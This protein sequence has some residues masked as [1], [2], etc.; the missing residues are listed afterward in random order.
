MTMTKDW[1]ELWFDS[2]YYDILYQHRD[3][4]EAQQFINGLLKHLAPQANARMLDLA[5][6]A[7]R[8]A[9]YLAEQGYD[10]TGVDLSDKN[11]RL[12]RKHEHEKLSFY[13]HDI[14]N[15]FWVNY[16]DYVFNFFTSFGY[17]NRD[18]DNMR[19]LRAA[20]WALKDGGILVID[21][22]NAEQVKNSLVPSE[23]K[24]INDIRF[25]ISRKFEDGYIIKSI[26]VA[27]GNRQ[28]HFEE[29]VQ[30]LSLDDFTRYFDQTGFELKEVFGS[31]QLEA[32]NANKSD[33]LLMIAQKVHA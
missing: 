10:V 24:V 11:I 27:D 33:R 23:V 3:M 21:F 15:T 2:T 31:Y 8:H 9:Y 28:K 7:G 17:F 20:N 29:R 12:A 14:R 1:F 6:G 32:Y 30:A 13:R 19:A 26:D 4:H 18:E 5:C 22:L 16:F 25:E